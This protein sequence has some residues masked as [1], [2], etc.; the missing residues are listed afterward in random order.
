MIPAAGEEAAQGLLEASSRTGV[1]LP[2]LLHGYPAQSSAHTVAGLQTGRSVLTRQ[3]QRREGP[4]FL[5]VAGLP[6]GVHS[7]ALGTACMPGTVWSVQPRCPWSD[8]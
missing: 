4:Q 1:V 5:Y 7:R 3:P 2:A 8:L 6:V